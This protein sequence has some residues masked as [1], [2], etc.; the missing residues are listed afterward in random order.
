METMKEMLL[1]RVKEK[2]IKKIEEMIEP[3][4]TPVITGIIVRIMIFERSRPIAMAI[5]III[6][7]GAILPVKKIKTSSSKDECFKRRTS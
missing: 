5:A 7:L 4:I 1:K 3:W 2:K 6:V